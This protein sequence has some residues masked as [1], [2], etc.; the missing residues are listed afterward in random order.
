MSPEQ[1]RGEGASPAWDL[2][3]LAVVAY[4]MLTGAQPFAGSGVAALSGS[5]VPVN[6]HLPEAPERWQQFFKRGFALDE[7][8]RPATARVFFSELKGTLS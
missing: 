5:F 8:Q 7:G 6:Q 4:E 1:L 2:W 3:A